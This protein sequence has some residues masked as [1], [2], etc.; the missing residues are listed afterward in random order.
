MMT[1]CFVFATL[2]LQILV[3][4]HRSASRP[5]LALGS[6]AAAVMGVA[7]AMMLLPV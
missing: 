2:L 5:L 7:A 3:P 6:I 4:Y 1:V